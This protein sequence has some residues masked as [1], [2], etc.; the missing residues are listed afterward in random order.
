M[1]RLA[2]PDHQ[3]A[4]GVTPASSRGPRTRS[5]VLQRRLQGKPPRADL[6]GVKGRRWLAELELRLEERESVDAVLRHVEF[7]DGEI[8]AVERGRERDT[9]A[10]M[11]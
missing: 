4:A 11:K 6:F 9:G 2:E 1:R 8:A 7:L 10:R 5:T 3:P